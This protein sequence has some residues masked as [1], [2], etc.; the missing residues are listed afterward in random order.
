MVSIKVAFKL[1]AINFFLT[2]LRTIT[3]IKTPYFLDTD[4]HRFCD[5]SH[6]N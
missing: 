4:L 5:D 2:L 1:T 3:F 6:V